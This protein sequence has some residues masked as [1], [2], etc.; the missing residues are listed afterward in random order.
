M[1]LALV[2]VLVLAGLVSFPLLNYR[3]A[4]GMIRSEASKILNVP[5]VQ[6]Q[7][8]SSDNNGSIL[9]NLGTNN[10]D[11]HLVNKGISVYGCKEGTSGKGG[12]AIFGCANGG[13][14][15]N[16]GR[17]GIAIFGTANAGNS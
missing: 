8:K 17:G 14:G 11:G 7:D 12:I 4:N 16:G 13:L 10:G 3:E 2:G 1:A 6:E 15:P 5:H 9:A